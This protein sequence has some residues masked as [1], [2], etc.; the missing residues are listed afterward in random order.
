MK[1]YKILIIILL[2]LVVVPVVHS[3]MESKIYLEIT[4]DYYS[5]SLAI[6]SI[7]PVFLE[8]PPVTSE[9]EYKIESLDKN[10]KMIYSDSFSIDLFSFVD[11][12]DGNIIEEEMV[13]FENVQKVIYLPY[14]KQAEK[15]RL[16]NQDD[17]NVLEY[18]L[19]EY[20]KTDENTFEEAPEG[21]DIDGGS[22][23][24]S[25]NKILI[26]IGVILGIVFILIIFFMGRRKIGE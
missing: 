11:Y 17:E 3:K 13:E 9:G 10:E 7:E 6:S 5:G 21:K 25:N 26:L 22:S 23:Q 18:S 14:Q 4:V 24:K 15:F 16:Y 2:I 19:E 20:S 12:V 1:Q 8:K